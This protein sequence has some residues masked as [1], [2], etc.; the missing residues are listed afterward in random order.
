MPV[1]FLSGIHNP[2]KASRSCKARAI[3]RKWADPQ[4][5][6]TNSINGQIGMSPFGFSSSFRN[7]IRPNQTTTGPV[8][9]QTADGEVVRREPLKALGSDL[10]PV[11]LQPN[12]PDAALPDTQAG[13]DFELGA[14]DVNFYKLR[15]SEFVGHH[16]IMDRAHFDLHL[17]AQ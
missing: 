13:K 1:S 8:L 3:G 2:A 10:G 5:A 9:S 6:K 15:R 14:F 17:I 11:G 7:P 4:A 12:T 16:Q